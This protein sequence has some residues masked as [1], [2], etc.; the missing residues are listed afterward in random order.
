MIMSLG[1][2]QTQQMML[3]LCEKMKNQRDYLCTL[4][5]NIG[6]GD[7]GDGI[8]Y[9][10]AA[11]E[12]LLQKKQYKTIKELFSES[13]FAMLQ[14]MGGASGVIFGSLFIGISKVLNEKDRLTTKTLSLGSRQALEDIKKRGGAELGD[15]TMVDSLEPAVRSLEKSTSENWPLNQALELASVSAEI[16]TNQTK[17]YVAKSG[18]AKNLGERTIGHPDPGAMSVY[19]IYQGMSAYL[20]NEEDR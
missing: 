14:S 11:I 19:L 17:K 2:T 6:D 12:E 8:Y 10:F 4:D 16:G 15:K 5:R 20:G 3:V 18:R 9:G 1:V 13:G 7:H